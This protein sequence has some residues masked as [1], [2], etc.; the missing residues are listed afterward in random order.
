MCCM[1]YNIPIA[2]NQGIR[3]IS[4]EVKFLQYYTF[5]ILKNIFIFLLI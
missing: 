1:F 2:Y 4:W 3:S 5:K